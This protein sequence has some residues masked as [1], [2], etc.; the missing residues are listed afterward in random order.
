MKTSNY[1]GISPANDVS[2]KSRINWLNKVY[3]IVKNTHKTHILGLTSTKVLKTFPCYSADSIKWKSGP[4]WGNVIDVKNKSP[5]SVYIT[6][7]SVERGRKHN[8]EKI[9][10]EEKLITELW[11][12]KGVEWD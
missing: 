4:I 3:S 12:K 10:K 5:L 8:T 11:K 2:L 6:R 7:S 1:I 9:L